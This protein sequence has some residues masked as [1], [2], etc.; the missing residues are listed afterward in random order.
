ME[1]KTRCREYWGR[2]DTELILGHLRSEISRG[3]SSQPW[4]CKPKAQENDLSL[5]CV[6][7]SC[8][9]RGG[10]NECRLWRGEGRGPGLS[11]KLSVDGEVLTTRLR[12]KGG[13]GWWQ[14]SQEKKE[15]KE[16]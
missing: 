2:A 15:P 12:R 14:E 9:P 8:G 1:G 16:C 10:E 11:P 3:L 13:R 6:V 7:G 4:V 5:S